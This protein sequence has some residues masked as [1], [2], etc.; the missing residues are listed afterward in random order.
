L[1]ADGK[2]GSRLERVWLEDGSVLVVKHADARGDWIMQATSDDGRIHRLWVEGVLDRLPTGLDHTIVDVHRG[3][4]GAVV[5]MRDVTDS[6]FTDGAGLRVG[7]RQ[8]L[9]ATAAMH[10]RFAREQP[11]HVCQLADYYAFLSPN[12]CARFAADHEVPRFAV[13][14]W[15]RFYELVDQDVAAAIQA[16]HAQPGRLADALADYPCT[17]VHGDLKLANLGAAA[18]VSVVLDWGTLTTW[19]PPA[20][21]FAWYLA[22]NAAALRADHDEL[23][24]AVEAVLARPDLD[25]LPLALFGALAQI[26]WEKALGATYDDPDIRAR[27]QTGLVWWSSQARVAL[28]TW[29]P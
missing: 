20:V 1:S 10:R 13:E 28:E 2:S 15:N 27:E 9:E 18:G 25:A 7:Q 11:R 6:L 29:S 19:A 23:R 4:A 26:G 16:V 17:L 8:L 22:L 21:D 5:V 24:R 3:E 14:G 12:V